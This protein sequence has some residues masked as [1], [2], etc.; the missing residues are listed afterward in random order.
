L[1][2]L[3][4]KIGNWIFLKFNWDL[5]LLFVVAGLVWWMCVCVCMYFFYAA[6]RWSINSFVRKKC[7][8]ILCSS[9]QY[10]IIDNSRH[11]ANI[12]SSPPFQNFICFLW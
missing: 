5:W 11:V 2:R 4:W 1:G 7:S 6:S 10:Q 9:F 8:S 12:R 3:C